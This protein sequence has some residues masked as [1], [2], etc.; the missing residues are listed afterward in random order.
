[1]LK[2][3]LLKLEDCQYHGLKIYYVPNRLKTFCTQTNPQKSLFWIKALGTYFSRFA[4]FL[5]V[6]Q[7]FQYILNGSDLNTGY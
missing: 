2:S 4:T 7:K 1:M 6:P 5:F 3:A